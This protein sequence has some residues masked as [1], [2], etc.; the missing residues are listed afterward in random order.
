M[1]IQ[2]VLDIDIVCEAG[3][4]DPFINEN[5]ILNGIQYWIEIAQERQ[6][7]HS[8]AIERLRLRFVKIWTQLE[9][10]R[11]IFVSFSGGESSAFLLLEI[12]KRYD[13]RFYN[14][15][16]CFAN[17][18]DEHEETL[19]FVFNIQNYYD[20]N[21][22]WLEAYVSP[23]IGKGVMP[24]VV[25]Y[26]TTSRDGK[27]M[28]DQSE[29]LGQC[30]ISATHCTRDLK[31]RTMHK[32]SKL[33]LGNLY[34]TMQGIRAD[35]TSRINWKSAKEKNWDYP[36]ARWG[37]TKPIINNFWSQH[38]EEH[39]FRLNLKEHQGN[40]NLCFKKSD[41]KLVKLLR[42]QPC[43]YIFRKTLELVSKNDKH[44]AYR[45]HRDIDDILKLAKSNTKQDQLSLF[46]GQCFCS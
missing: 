34:T 22:T 37:V 19:R 39:G 42:E 30:A 35:E 41:S 7:N 24:I 3:I 13:A 38:E 33:V 4:N 45:G 23:I 44:D 6:Y 16:V 15:L 25:D 43:L 14:I 28:L 46:G 20:V 29:K 1:T 17:V 8:A 18:G 11:N 12:I 2:Q 32:H 31:I 36:L 26:E 9:V 10:K 21:I 27:P 5:I 40:C